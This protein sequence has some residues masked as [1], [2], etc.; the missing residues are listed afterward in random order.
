MDFKA[1][2]F[3]FDGTIAD[4]LHAALRIGNRLAPEYGYRPVQAGEIEALRRLPYRKV[5]AHIGLAWHKI[6]RVA[7]RIRSELSSRLEEVQPIAGLPGVLSELRAR[8]FR[9]GILSSNSRS[10]VQR[11]LDAHGL[12]DFEFIS[13]AS[14]VWGKQRRLRAVL[15]SRGLAASD[16]VY[17][18]DEVRDIEATKALGVR[19]IAVTWGYTAREHLAAHGPDHLV[20]RPDELLQ[21]LRGNN[22]G[23]AQELVQHQV[24]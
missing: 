10:N 8:G 2:I 24:G 1:V 12:D 11:F 20:D 14:S 5:A 17:V 7:T 21:I 9:L 19:V 6:P 16:V 4:S 3:D 23:G 13:T 18:G 22:T 15:K